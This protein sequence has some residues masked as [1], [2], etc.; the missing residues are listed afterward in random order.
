MSPRCRLGLLVALPVILGKS[1]SKCGLPGKSLNSRKW[2]G[3]QIQI[4]Y[5]LTSVH[6]L[7][8]LDV[9]PQQGS[10]PCRRI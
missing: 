3:G 9:P 7:G 2:Y 6:N 1:P 10:R 5:D 4:N 8:F